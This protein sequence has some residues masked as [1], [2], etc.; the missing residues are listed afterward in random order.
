MLI[1][2]LSVRKMDHCAKRT[3][4]SVLGKY[5][6]ESSSTWGMISSDFETKFIKDAYSKLYIIQV[7][8]EFVPL[9]RAK[10]IEPAV[11]ARSAILSSPST[12]IVSSHS[13]MEC[14]LGQFENDDGILALNTTVSDI[15]YDMNRQLYSVE[16]EADD[17]NS[18]KTKTVLKFE[19]VINAAGHGAPGV[20][21]ML[22]P[23]ERHVQGFYGKGSYF[24]YGLSQ[25]KTQRLVFK[26]RYIEFCDIVR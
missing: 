17:E 14:L 24:S 9:S 5:A 15:E 20:S 2:Q 21:N 1:C 6:C 23:A 8:A 10:D 22:L 3:R 25:P 16:F 18:E 26:Q 19:K 4:A 11:T 12:G 13:L 7:P